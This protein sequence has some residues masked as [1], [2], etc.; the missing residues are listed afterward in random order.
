MESFFNFRQEFIKNEPIKK[1]KPVIRIAVQIDENHL[2]NNVISFKDLFRT[3][4]YDLNKT[5]KKHKENLEV[6]E[7]EEELKSDALSCSESEEYYE[8]TEFED[9]VIEED[10]SKINSK[11]TNNV[12]NEE[13]SKILNSKQPLDIKK[14]V[15]LRDTIAKEKIQNIEMDLLKK[16]KRK[17][18]E[19]Y[20]MNDPFIDDSEDYIIENTTKKIEKKEQDFIV[21]SGKYGNEK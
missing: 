11:C 2:E 14:A 17:F 19:Y 16:K 21:W 8:K 13:L 15:Y 10:I 9:N 7:S 5:G 1:R 6:T 3:S 18:Y 4:T 20:D 12:L